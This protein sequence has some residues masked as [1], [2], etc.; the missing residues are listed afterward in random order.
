MSDT[1]PCN[2]ARLIRRQLFDGEAPDVPPW[3]A[4]ARPR[5]TRGMLGVAVM[6]RNA[7]A[8]KSLARVLPQLP[9]DKLRRIRRLADDDPLMLSLLDAVAPGQCRITRALLIDTARDVARLLQSG[10]DPVR[11][12]LPAA[13]RRHTYPARVYDDI[14]AFSPWTLPP[15]MHM[16]R[17]VVMRA[18]W[19]HD[20]GGLVWAFLRRRSFWAP[21][22]LTRPVPDGAPDG[23]ALP[24]G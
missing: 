8:V 7:G 9:A 1:D 4:R 5:T 18:P 19:G 13:V 11:G 14:L 20:V 16:A 21:R 17:V 24:R 22:Q 3:F 2:T 15:H 6:T 12:R 23:P 10:V